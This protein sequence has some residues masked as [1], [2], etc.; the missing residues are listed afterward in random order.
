MIKKEEM[1]KCIISSVEKIN[2]FFYDA[3][4]SSLLV[5]ESKGMKFTPLL[6]KQISASPSLRMAFKLSL[7]IVLLML[8]YSMVSTM[9]IVKK[10]SI[11]RGCARACPPQ[12]NPSRFIC[13]KNQVTGRLGMFDSECFFGRYNHCIYVKQSKS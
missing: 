11:P 5:V 1:R 6:Q 4:H 3:I 13:G 8:C 7:L 10:V 12:T 2:Q 9:F